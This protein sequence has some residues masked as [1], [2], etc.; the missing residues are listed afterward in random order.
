MVKRQLFAFVFLVFC[1]GAVFSGIE[2]K[3]AEVFAGQDLHVRGGE[4]ISYQPVSGEHILVLSGGFLMSIGGDEFFSDEAVVWLESETTRYRGRVNVDYK[5]KIYLASSKSFE[6]GK[7]TLTVDLRRTIVEDGKSMV[8][9][10]DVTGEIFVTAEKRE[11]RDVR[12]LDFYKRAVAALEP[13]KL[14][15]E[16][17]AEPEATA[18]EIVEKEEA[19][20]DKK[21]EL[22]SEEAE[23]KEPLK[24]G[25][26][27]K[28]KRAEIEFQYPVNFAPAGAEPLKLESAPSK[29]GDIATIIGRL[30]VWQKRDERGG[31]LE[32][33]ADNAV[34][35]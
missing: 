32:L 15:A 20:V 30:Y 16:A 28:S 1:A 11:V 27:V 7:E 9:E 29:D 17:A 23:A 6:K 19:Q 35:Y 5:A 21:P 24:R 14:R 3:K 26:E 4:L 12:G 18:T 25:I 10:F 34:V 33:Q 13:V 31:L 2:D 8:V 22:K